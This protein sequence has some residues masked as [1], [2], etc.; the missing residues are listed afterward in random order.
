VNLEVNS[1]GRA[2]AAG[3]RYGLPVG[4]IKPRSYARAYYLAWLFKNAED[5]RTQPQITNTN[6]APPSYR[7]Q[8]QHVQTK[9]QELSKTDWLGALNA[10]G[11]SGRN[12]LRPVI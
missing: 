9:P 2:G 3:D 1:F 4:E 6:A 10:L 12:R 5:S 7:A 11:N 8:S